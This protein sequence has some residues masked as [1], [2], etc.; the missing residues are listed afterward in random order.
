MRLSLPFHFP[1]I[2][3]QPHWPEHP[4]QGWGRSVGAFTASLCFPSHLL[5]Q[6]A[7]SPYIQLDALLQKGFT[8]H[9]ALNLLV[10]LHALT[11]DI[12]LGRIMPVLLAGLA[13]CMLIMWLGGQIGQITVQYMASKFSSA[14]KPSS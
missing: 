13:L 2:P 11:P 3:R 5:A 8:P 12:L 7:F 14:A 6:L 9:A 1:G 4:A 10:Q